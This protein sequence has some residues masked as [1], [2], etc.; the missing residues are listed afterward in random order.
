MPRI[1]GKGKGKTI[2]GTIPNKAHHFDTRLI[3]AGLIVAFLV[4]LF[5]TFCYILGFW[6]TVSLLFSPW[7]LSLLTITVIVFISVILF[8]TIF[9]VIVGRCNTNKLLKQWE[10]Q[11]NQVTVGFLHPYCS[12][13]GGGERVLW[14]SIQ[15]LQDRYS[16]VQCVIYTAD[17][18]GDN[19]KII[20]GVRRNF[21]IQLKRPVKFIH[22]RS[23]NVL[24]LKTWPLSTL[25]GQS[26]TS[27]WVGAEA[28]ISFIPNVFIDTTGLAFNLILFKWLGRCKTSCYVHYPTIS[29]DMLKVVENQTQAF[30][31]AAWISNSIIMTKLKVFYYKVFSMLYSLVGNRSDVVMVN[32]SWT[33][34]HIKQ[35]WNPKRLSIVYPPCDTSAFMYASATPTKE[36]QFRVVSVGQFRPEKNHEMQINILAK[37]LENVQRKDSVVFVFIGSCRNQE[38]E[39]YLVT[40]KEYAIQLGI[41]KKNIEWKTGIPF[42]ELKK[43][44]KKATA[45]LHV[46]SNEHFGIG[47]VE[48]MAAGCVIVAHNSGGPRMDIVKEWKGAMTGL[49]ADTVDSFVEQLLIVYEMS[50]EQRE[51]VVSTAQAS[52]NHRFSVECFHT[53]F[54][55][56]TE[57]LFNV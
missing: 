36:G 12:A 46:M 44:L 28:L 45:G 40:L 17:S 7:R 53:N 33:H 57:A 22:L 5:L 54:L 43:E 49:L 13:G 50:L 26:I 4:W 20:T 52:V 34:G 31:N 11:D 1:K 23:T 8:T 9:I 25:L 41:K 18:K 42:E 15:A 35:L 32:S 16:F 3:I 19:D 14:N 38:D 37:L 30:N 47:V 24:K 51:A 10:Q 56:A 27:M 6:N 21:N 48:C 55:R 29:T 2:S 39:H